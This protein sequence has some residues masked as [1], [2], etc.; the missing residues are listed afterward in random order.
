[1]NG[2]LGLRIRLRVRGNRQLPRPL[3]HRKGKLL[4][5]QMLPL[6][7]DGD[8]DGERIFVLARREL[9]DLWDGDVLPLA[10]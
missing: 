10:G 8:G 2:I 3:K 1:M 9:Y 6:T 7:I 4:I 5:T